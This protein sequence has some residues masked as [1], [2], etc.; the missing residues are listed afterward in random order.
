MAIRTT[1][2]TGTVT[3]LGLILGRSRRHGIDK[4]KAAVLTVTL[5]L[6]LAGGAAGLLIGARLGGYAL[7]VPAVICG[8]VAIASVLHD[9]RRRGFPDLT[10]SAPTQ[11]LS[12]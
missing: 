11:T 4:R 10:N 5:L 7:V 2:F 3:D 6:F 8:A 1:H 9:R 12:R